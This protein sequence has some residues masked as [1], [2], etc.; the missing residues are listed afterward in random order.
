[1]VGWMSG[2][3]KNLKTIAEG[4]LREGE[5]GEVKQDD[6][7]GTPMC[8]AWFG[9]SLTSASRVGVVLVRPVRQGPCRPEYIFHFPAALCL[10]NSSPG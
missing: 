9:G 8:R 10:Q 2:R 3:T 5:R 7:M 1:M 6:E 4:T